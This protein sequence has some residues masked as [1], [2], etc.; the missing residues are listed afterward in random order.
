M[1]NR[2]IAIISIT[3][4][5]VLL[6]FSTIYSNFD[7][8]QAYAGVTLSSDNVA[9]S[10]QVRV[11]PSGTLE[12]RAYDSFSRVGFVDGENNFLL[13][14]VP[15]KDKRSY[16]ELL[17]RSIEDKRA[18]SSDNR[19]HVSIDLFSGDGEIIQSLEY[20]DCKVT[21]YFV[22][23]VDSKGKI[24]FTE[25]DGT[26][27]I[28]EVSKFSCVSFTLN[29]EP[30]NAGLVI[31]KIIDR[32]VDED[33]DEFKFEYHGDDPYFSVNPLNSTEGELFY[34]SMTNTLQKFVNGE[35]VDISG[36]G[37]PPSPRR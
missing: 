11:T 10:I 22:H 33:S 28:R 24:F 32:F 17:K 5:A 20:R 15:S 30:R 29:L 37:G 23:G 13:E 19:I 1:D 36:K 7:I 21:E 27:E 12:E 3:S 31:D 14:S 26:V 18:E 6:T 9:K 8:L 35:W 4:V 2:Q 25:E 34:N 16:Y